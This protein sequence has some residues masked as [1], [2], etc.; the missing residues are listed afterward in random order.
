MWGWMVVAFCAVAAITQ[1]EAELAER[2][3]RLLRELRV[4]NRERLVEHQLRENRSVVGTFGAGQVE[5]QRTREAERHQ[6]LLL[7]NGVVA[8]IA[9]RADEFLGADIPFGA[10]EGGPVAHVQRVARPRLVLRRHRRQP[11]TQPQDV[12]VL[13][14]D[15]LL[16]A[17]PDLGDAPRDRPHDLGELGHRRQRTGRGAQRESGAAVELHRAQA[18]C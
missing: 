2:L 5:A 7:A 16:V 8:C 13:V 11:V 9:V 17:Q 10:V 3:Q 15:R 1:L 4:R 18:P 14:V 12:G 6:L